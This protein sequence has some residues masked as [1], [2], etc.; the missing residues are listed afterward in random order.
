MDIYLLR[1]GK[2]SYN[3]EKRYLG[4]SDVSLSAK[5]LAELIP[6]GFSPQTV[7]VSP[8]RRTWET[9]RALFR[10]PGQL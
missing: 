8:L 7:Y 1:H 9:A 10:P 6:A 5:G 3:A 4:R 2:T